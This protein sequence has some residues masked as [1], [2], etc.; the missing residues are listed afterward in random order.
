MHRGEVSRGQQTLSI[1]HFSL[2]GISAW[3]FSLAFQPCHGK[4]LHSALANDEMS[5]GNRYWRDCAG[6]TGIFSPP[7]AATYL[8]GNGLPVSRATGLPWLDATCVNCAGPAV[9]LP[10][11]P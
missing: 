5:A 11:P 2:C 7:L 3:H 8:L 4:L 6:A 9:L 1:W 10:S